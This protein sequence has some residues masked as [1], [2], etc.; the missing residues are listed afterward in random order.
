MKLIALTVLL[1]PLA[2]AAQQS[3]FKWADI[4]GPAVR[5]P[6][7]KSTAFY[8]AEEV[9][10]AGRSVAGWYIV[11]VVDADHAS[12]EQRYCMPT[13]AKLGQVL[14]VVWKHLEENPR[15]RHHGAPYFVRRALADAWPCT[16]R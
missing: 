16:R 10:R 14:D 11:G 5:D 12:M 3:E 6:I 1:L 13:G 15:D 2:A 9:Y 7:E 4:I 8:T